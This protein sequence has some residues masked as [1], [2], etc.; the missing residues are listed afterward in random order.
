MIKNILILASILLLASC[1]TIS[2]IARDDAA[3]KTWQQRQLSLASINQWQVSGRI[4]IRANN[5]SEQ[6]NLRWL[7]NNSHHEIDLSGPLNVGHAHLTLDS[8]KVKLVADNKTYHAKNA[9]QLLADVNGWRLPING[10]EYWIRGLPAPDA[11]SEQVLDHRNRLQQLIQSEWE[12]LYQSYTQAG[13][14]DLPR[15]IFIKRIPS[16]VDGPAEL[17]EIR[18]AI[19]SWHGLE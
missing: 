7:K 18:I 2:P 8:E 15:I 16:V 19:S 14:R 1:T 12:I 9:E 11:Q 3:I 4:S 5:E 10:L 6:M 13:E 17:I